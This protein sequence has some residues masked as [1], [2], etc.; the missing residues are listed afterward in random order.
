LRK[1]ANEFVGVGIGGGAIASIILGGYGAG[2]AVETVD[3]QTKAR[4]GIM[5]HGSMDSTSTDVLR[6]LFARRVHD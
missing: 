5:F 2:Q 6:N 3:E 1:K 4:T